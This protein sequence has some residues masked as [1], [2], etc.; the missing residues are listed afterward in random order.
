MNWPF[1]QPPHT[2]FFQWWESHYWPHDNRK[3][4]QNIEMISLTRLSDILLVR[5]HPERFKDITFIF[6]D[7]INV[8]STS[9]VALASILISDNTPDRYASP[10]SYNA[11]WNTAWKALA[12]WE[13]L[14]GIKPR[15]D[16]E[17]TNGKLLKQ[18][19]LYAKVASSG[20]KE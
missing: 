19:V 12:N 15:K 2:V 4:R 17:L 10:T 14:N 18:N 7:R 3:W 8:G 11:A 16:W 20:T 13:T 6:T 1:W 5:C 9:K